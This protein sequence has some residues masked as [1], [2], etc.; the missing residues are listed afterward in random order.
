MIVWMLMG[1]QGTRFASA[2]YSLPKPLLPVGEKR[3]VQ[4]AM[5]SVQGLGGTLHYS[6]WVDTALHRALTGLLPTGCWHVVIKPTLGP[7]QTI[8]EGAACLDRQE[9]LLICDCDSLINASELAEALKIFRHSHATGGVTLRRTTDPWCSYARITQ[10]WVV[11]ETRNCD[12][13]S[14]WSTTGPYWFQSATDFLVAGR[15]AAA[16]HEVAIS[17]VYNFLEGPVRGV[18]VESFRHLGTPAAYEA[19]CRV[20][21]EVG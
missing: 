12:P 1:G 20:L 4:L 9:E 6:L 2:G 7:L 8:L 14:P 3:L 21:K 11:E 17:P 16:A 18:P 15:K 13:F 10:E 19:A 5:E